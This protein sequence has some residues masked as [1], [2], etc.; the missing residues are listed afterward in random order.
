MPFAI[1]G[2]RS[3][4]GE[5][6]Q[7]HKKA[8]EKASLTDDEADGANEEFERLNNEML[9]ALRPAY[10]EITG[11]DNEAAIIA[12]APNALYAEIL[13]KTSKA[14]LQTLFQRLSAKRAGHEQAP[15]DTRET[16]AIERLFR[17]ITASGE[18]LEGRLADRFGEDKARAIRDA[19]DGFG[20]K[21]G[22][23]YGCP[24]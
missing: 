21:Y 22:S 14:H 4:L 15:E 13:D 2:Q 8:R 11:D 9:T 6:P 12:I 20:S 7:L 16:A 10:M 5:A 24:D 1:V 19:R 23:S 17:A 18:T 3:C